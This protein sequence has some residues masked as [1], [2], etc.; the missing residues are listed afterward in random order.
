M[1][2]EGLLI[3]ELRPG[4]ALPEPVVGVGAE[5]VSICIGSFSMAVLA[6]VS[7]EEGLLATVGGEWLPSWAAP[8]ELGSAAGAL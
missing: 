1:E 7:V 4:E 2:P 6:S 8:P 3:I 5:V